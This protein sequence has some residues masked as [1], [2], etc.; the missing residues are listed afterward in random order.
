[1]HHLPRALGLAFGMGRWA[2]R[3]AE[4]TD[5]IVIC[6][7]GDASANHST[8]T[9]ALNAAGYC[10]H[11]GIALPLLFVC[12]DNG[13]GISTRTPDGWT[14]R[15]LA[16]WPGLTYRAVDGADAPATLDAA[17]E[18]VDKVRATRTPAILHLA[19]NHS[20]RPRRSTP[21]SGQR[22][23]ESIEASAHSQCTSMDIINLV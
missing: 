14:A 18:I 4:P 12:E 3:A 21:R 11:Q 17:T 9:G 7:F 8:A 6:S 13:I 22:P 20:V 15:S 16:S 1:M 23:S 19:E 2:S 10:S 5:A